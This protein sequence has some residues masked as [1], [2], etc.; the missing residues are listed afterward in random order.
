MSA[1]ATPTLAQL[2][3]TWCKV[4]TEQPARAWIG[5]VIPGCRLADRPKGRFE[6]STEALHEPDVVV[7]RRRKLQHLTSS[8]TD[9][10][11]SCYQSQSLFETQGQAK[12]ML[13]F[14]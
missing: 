7:V 11:G 9:Q 4:L 13:L 6:M 10:H 3:E 2:L 8:R 5:D 12:K 14:P 1:G